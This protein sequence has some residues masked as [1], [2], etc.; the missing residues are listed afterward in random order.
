M[1]L[2]AYEA[3]L[4]NKN[5]WLGTMTCSKVKTL[6]HICAPY[7]Q[8][9]ELVNCVSMKAKVLI[10]LKRGKNMLRDYHPEV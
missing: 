10:P 8:M 1:I 4:Y 2:N 9:V 7:V 6:S 5:L 3:I